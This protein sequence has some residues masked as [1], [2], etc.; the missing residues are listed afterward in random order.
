MAASDRNEYNGRM[1]ITTLLRVS[2]ESDMRLWHAVF[3]AMQ[4]AE[5]EDLPADPF[6]EGLPLLAGL[7][8]DEKQAFLVLLDEDVPVAAASVELPLKEN[9]DMAWVELAVHPNH[10]RCGHG[11]RML[12]EI[13]R[14]SSEYGRTRV[15]GHVWEPYEDD[16]PMSAS[17]AFATTFGAELKNADVRRLLDLAALDPALLAELTQNALDH[18]EGYSLVQWTN[19]APEEWHDDLAQLQARM[20]TDI[21]LGDL[22]WDAAVWDAQRWVDKEDL[23]IARGRVR[24]GTAVRHEATGRLIGY[25]DIGIS[26]AHDVGYQWDTI[27]APEHRGHRLGLLMKVANLEYLLASD[28]NVRVINTWNAAANAHMIAVNDALGFRPVD[29]WGEWELPL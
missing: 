28:L 5:Y 8:Q 27:V 15:L 10:R 25:T 1:A 3:A 22:K 17:K 16:A 9:L 24:F 21:P 19:R 14:V 6:E 23:C 12:D 13:R 18:A 4:A 29:R 2:D 20:S 26:P 11:R 7:D